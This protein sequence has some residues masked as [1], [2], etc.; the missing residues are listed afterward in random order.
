MLDCVLLKG[1]VSMKTLQVIQSQFHSHYRKK[2]NQTKNYLEIEELSDVAPLRTQFSLSRFWLNFLSPSCRF[3]LHPLRSAPALSESMV[4]SPMR[5]S[6]SPKFSS[7][8]LFMSKGMVVPW[9]ADPGAKGD[10]DGP[11]GLRNSK[12]AGFLKKIG[13]VLT[14]EWEICMEQCELTNA[15]CGSFLSLRF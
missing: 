6:S 11:Q 13:I 3:I 2:P 4:F 10:S 1:R 12:M 8:T 5:P 7:G 15:H 14:K 9:I